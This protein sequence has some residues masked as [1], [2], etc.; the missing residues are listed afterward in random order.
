MTVRSRYAEDELEKAVRNGMTQY[1]L[2][3]AGLD[4]FAYRRHDLVERLSVF[5]VDYPSTQQW[6]RGRLRELNTPVPSNLT[7]VPVDFERQT[8]IE[9]LSAAGYRVEEPAFFSWLG[10]TQYLAEDAIVR[11]LQEIASLVTG[12]EIVFE[13]LVP[14]ER[15]EGVE[16][17]YLA[18][19][20]AGSARR[21]EP[22]R[23]CFEPARLE[24][25]VKGL[26]FT[27]FT[28]LDA[29]AINARY[30]ANRRD[31][32]R[33]PSADHLVRARVGDSP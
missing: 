17:E 18:S 23:G 10:V 30:F 24:G 7:F 31:G 1:V 27:E 8:L 5:E 4:S 6:K 22:W 16:R 2:L 20:K 14:E 13:Y 32:L 11:T 26:R 15:L 21:G 3:G 25:L 19:V 9:A 29:E 28:D 33:S 12:S